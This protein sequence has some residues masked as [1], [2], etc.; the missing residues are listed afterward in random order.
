[1]QDA[2]DEVAQGGGSVIL[3]TV[4][5]NG[6]KTFAQILAEFASEISNLSD[7]SYIK[8]T[9]PTGVDIYNV[10][11]I[12]STA[13]YFVY[14]FLT[15]TAAN[16]HSYIVGST[17]YYYAWAGSTVT[18]TSSTVATSGLVFDLYK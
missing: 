14:S 12:D 17:G 5:A 11:H 16:M 3:K 10:C 7:H 9:K 2:I 18:N 6:T 15:S 8:L 13:A 4:T 1:M